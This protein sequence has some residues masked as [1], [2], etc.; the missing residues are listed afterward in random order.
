MGGRAVV[1][2]DSNP[3][4][5]P[6]VEQSSRETV[7]RM[8]REVDRARQEAAEAQESVQ[9]AIDGVAC[10]LRVRVRVGVGLGA[11]GDGVAYLLSMGGGLDR[12]VIW[13][14]YR[15]C[16]PPSSVSNL[17]PTCSATRRSTKYI[18]AIR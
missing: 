17:R 3:N 10:L 12:P 8:Q 2:G 9:Q 1:Q 6:K 15:I 16:S 11:A 13:L 4:H 18:Y 7:E 14:P 5:N